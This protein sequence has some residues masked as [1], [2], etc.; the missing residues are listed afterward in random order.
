MNKQNISQGSINSHPESLSGVK[1]IDLT[2]VLGGP[3]CTQMLSD[4]GADIIKVE[5][6]HGDET[7]EWGP[8]FKD[9]SASY[10]IGVNRNKKSIALDFKKQEAR[11]I[12]LKMLEDADILIENFKLG[13]LEKWGLGYDEVLSKKFPHLIHCR[14]T[15]FGKEGPYGGLAGY[16][17][18]AQALSGLMSINGSDEMP[19]V[20]VG[21]PI[22]DLAAGLNAAFGLM[23]ALYRRQISGY[24]QSIEISLY[25]TGVSLLHPQAANWFLSGKQQRNT[26][27][28]HPNIAPY[29]QFQTKTGRVFI[30]CG[31]DKQFKILCEIIGRDDL[32]NDVKYQT[33]ALRVENRK[34]LTKELEDEFKDFDA[35]ELSDQLLEKGVPAGAVS[36]IEDVFNHKQTIAREMMIDW[37]G[38]KGIGMPVKMSKTP[39]QVKKSLPPQFNEHGIQIL[40]NL[41]Y[42][43][44]QIN[45]FFKNDIVIA[46]KRQ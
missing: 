10:F 25:D 13:T 2:R 44:K 7:R 45:D 27:D 29:S 46:K 1:V 23:M 32:A 31:N 18:V 15:G 5:P 19:P 12:L 21:V 35:R 37:K 4:H 22:I 6:P 39:G 28:A 8:P 41:G 43:E 42:S 3:Y 33:N 20:R 24:G 26:G 11:D 30:G 38:Y 16:D 17:A 40:K 36:N 9:G 34:V 14:I